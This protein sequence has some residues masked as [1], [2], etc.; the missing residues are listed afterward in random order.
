MP[1]TIINSEIE[2]GALIPDQWMVGTGLTTNSLYVTH[3]AAPLMIMQCADDILPDH[4]PALCTLYLQGTI[5]PEKID[6]LL[7]QG[8]ELLKIYHDRRGKS[9]P[10]L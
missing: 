8:L 10:P 6:H 9:D 3:L 7:N 4:P 5:A 2:N 1:E